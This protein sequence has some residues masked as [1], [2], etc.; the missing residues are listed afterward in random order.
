[1]FGKPKDLKVNQM[2]GYELAEWARR[3]GDGRLPSMKRKT[4]KNWLKRKLG[5]QRLNSDTI[6]FQWRI[7]RYHIA[8]TINSS[9][10]QVRGQLE[11]VKTE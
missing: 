2:A 11:Q 6:Y 9:G 1:L 4:M 10:G 8:V 5:Y 7:G 3:F